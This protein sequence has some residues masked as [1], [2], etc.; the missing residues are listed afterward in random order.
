MPA[1]VSIIMPAYNA[2][3][4]LASSVRSVLEQTHSD[5]E[6][7]LIVDVKSSDATLELAR[8]FA[9]QEPRIRLISGL[10]RGG[11]VFNR[12]HGLREAAGD[13]ICLLDSDDL[14]HPQKLEKQISF[15]EAEKADITCTGYGWMGWDGSPLP[16]VVMPP[17]RITH[18]DMLLENHI[19]CLTVMLRR[20]RYPSL[21][22]VEFL[23]EDYILW[24]QLTRDTAARGLRE[25]LATYRLARHSRSGNKVHAATK[26]W[27]ILRRFEKL[28]LPRALW[29]F[30][31]YAFGAMRKRAS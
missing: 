16:T 31:H 28:S 29:C 11:C 23:H 24:L 27:Q 25:N 22:F 20:S 12:N 21:E 19:G 30:T 15:M 14:W 4:T 8:G 5:W 2:A 18:A 3:A 26:R 9:A 6:L 1:K 7:L 17:E 13:F 10:E